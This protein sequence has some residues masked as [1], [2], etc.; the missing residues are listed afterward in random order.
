MVLQASP[1]NS[2]VWGFV[3]SSQPP[4]VVRVCIGGGG[5]N[6]VD[7]RIEPGPSDSTALIFSAVLPKMPPASTAY[8]IT[9][10]T[11]GRAAIKLSEVVWGD[12]YVCSGQ[13]NEMPNRASLS[14]LSDQVSEMPNRAPVEYGLRCADGIQRLRRG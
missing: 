4:P 10:T 11:A 13:V 8:T 9:A 12:V 14:R 6:C 7:A 3:P 1:Q 5:G 2:I